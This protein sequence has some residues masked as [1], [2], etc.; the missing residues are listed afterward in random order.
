MKTKRQGRHGAK[1]VAKKATVTLGDLIA[2][3]FD[4]VGTEV[5]EVARVLSSKDMAR[6][7]GRRIV[8]V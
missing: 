1:A 5:K 8:V 2:A 7:T 3:A 4:T 6:L